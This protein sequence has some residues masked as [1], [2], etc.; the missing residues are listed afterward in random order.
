MSLGRITSRFSRTVLTQ[1]RS[2]QL[3][4]DR[5]DQ[6]YFRII[7]N[8][9]LSPTG[10]QE[11]VSLLG[12]STLNSSTFQWFGFSSSASPHP[13]EKEN[14]ESEN[15]QENKR[16][17]GANAAAVDVPDQSEASVS[18]QKDESGL[19]MKPPSN[20]SGSVKR[21]KRGTKRLAFSDSDSD[22]ESDLSRDDLMKLL[23]EKEELLKVKQI[24]HEQMKDK[25]LRT[26]AEM[27]NVKDRTKREADNAKKFA[28]QNFAKSLLD[29]ADNLGRASSAAKES[30]S[31][32]ETSNGAP[33]AVT[34]LKTLLE[35]VEMTEKQLIEVFKKFGVE[36][37]DV[38]NEEFDPNRHN[39]V[40][41][42]PDASKPA[43]HVA[44]V[45]KA[46][47][48]LHDRVIRPAE[49][50]VTVA[51]DNVDADK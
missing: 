34:Q 5:H 46:G 14:A 26:L 40:F 42:V 48:M 43:N 1:C 31:K 23:A 20:T 10:S 13:N 35:G 36:K 6:M 50:G 12:H 27:E 9:F 7:S 47:Y 4:C 25:V 38:M 24:E 28:I 2:S 29:V 21:R 8:Q 18:D 33:G 11:K 15:K 51:V 30:F 45:L 44:V 41:Q 22:L 19:K 37:Y 49:V 32:I 3:L 17:D 16:D 39:A